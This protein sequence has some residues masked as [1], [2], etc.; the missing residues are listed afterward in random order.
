MKPVKI[1]VISL[2]IAIVAVATLFIRIP[3]V[4]TK[5][6]FNLGD[7]AIF[8]S[9]LLFGPLAGAMAGGIGSA[10]ADVLGG[11]AV[12]APF[13]LVIKGI[14]GLLVGKLFQSFGADMK[15]RKGLLVAVFVVLLGGAW[16]MA[17]YLIAQMFMFGWPAALSELPLNFFQAIFGLVISLPVSVALDR[18]EVRSIW[19]R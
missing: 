13:T 14:E 12:Y 2:L 15:S 3:I 8:V 6:Y 19:E 9:A 4:A 11:Y 7:S 16:M 5:G 1:A 10:L 18:A 17:G